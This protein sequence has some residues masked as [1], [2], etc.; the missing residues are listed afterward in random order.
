MRCILS[1][2]SVFHNGLTLRNIYKP[3]DSLWIRFTKN[4]TRMLRR[5]FLI[6]VSISSSS[7]SS[8]SSSSSSSNFNSR[9]TEHIIYAQQFYNNFKNVFIWRLPEKMRGSSSWQQLFKIKQ[10]GEAGCQGGYFIVPICVENIIFSKWVGL[11]FTYKLMI[12]HG[13][14][15]YDIITMT[16][17]HG[18]RRI[19]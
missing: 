19:L 12:Q 11:I 3:H 13:A 9:T 10:Q 2:P 8:N 16:E 18:S 15:K 4:A 7:S 14:H 17:Y 1:F 5:L 6:Y